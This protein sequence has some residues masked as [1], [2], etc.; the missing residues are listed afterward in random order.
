MNFVNQ[1]RRRL[2]MKAESLRD[3]DRKEKP[4]SKNRLK[5]VV[6][7]S[8]AVLCEDKDSARTESQTARSSR[9]SLPLHIDPANLQQR[10]LVNAAEALAALWKIS[11]PRRTKLSSPA[12]QYSR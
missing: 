10:A 4:D 12:M 9:R 6:E 3:L 11:G 2:T 1:N 5:S 8:L 7:E